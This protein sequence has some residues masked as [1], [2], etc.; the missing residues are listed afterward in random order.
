MINMECT[1]LESEK[2][3]I[4]INY[5]VRCSGTDIFFTDKVRNQE[6]GI[7]YWVLTGY[8]F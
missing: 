4:M 6:K 7:F 5:S 8:C 3:I 1:E 2:G